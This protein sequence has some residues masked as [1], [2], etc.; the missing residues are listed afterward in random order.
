MSEVPEILTKLSEVKSAFVADKTGVVLD[1]YNSKNSSQLAAVGAYAAHS[2][3]SVEDR[4]GMMEL[5]QIKISGGTKTL[6][7]NFNEEQIFA[8]EGEASLPCKKIK[9]YFEAL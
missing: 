8:V 4:L 3:K 7:M 2:L 9:E 5:T 1:N 6:L